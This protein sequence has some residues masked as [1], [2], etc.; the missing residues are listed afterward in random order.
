MKTLYIKSDIVEVLNSVVSNFKRIVVKNMVYSK[1]TANDEVKVY[2]DL[3]IF[4]F[5]NGYMKGFNSDGEFRMFIVDRIQEI[6]F[7][8][9]LSLDIKSFLKKE[10]KRVEIINN[11]RG[12]LLPIAT[13]KYKLESVKIFLE[14]QNYAVKVDRLIV[15]GRDSVELTDCIIMGI[16]EK[17]FKVIPTYDKTLILTFP[18]D[19]LHSIGNIISV[20][21]TTSKN[22]YSYN[23]ET[24]V[25]LNDFKLTEKEL[26]IDT[27]FLDNQSKVSLSSGLTKINS[28]PVS[29]MEEDLED[30]PKKE[31]LSG[32]MVNLLESINGMK[33][34]MDNN[35]LGNML[36]QLGT[37]LK[38]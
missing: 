16:D 9:I 4:A 35:E 34:N 25:S 29:S 18:L 26:M 38:D 37:L 17:E 28:I 23:S 36:I 21:T 11:G 1:L 19:K 27:N 13:L 32:D 8:D 14:R 7:G 6:T 20:Y 3:D 30:E 22:P 5:D 33:L 12:N 2:D 10:E 15:V 31:I 24:E